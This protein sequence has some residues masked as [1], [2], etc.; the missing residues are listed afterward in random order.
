MFS[1][2]IGTIP[3][4]TTDTTDGFAFTVNVNLDGTTTVNNFST[5]TTVGPATTSTTPEPSSLALVITGVSLLCWM[6]W[7][8]PPKGN[9]ALASV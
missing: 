6:V 2:A 3:T 8:A 7:A 5:Q 4:L 9:S 1:D